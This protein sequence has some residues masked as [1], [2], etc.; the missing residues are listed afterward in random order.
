MDDAHRI[1]IPT[2]FDV[3]R[4]NCYVFA[5][6]PLT[7]VD[8]GPATDAAY[9]ELAAGLEDLGY[10]VADVEQVL[11]THPH[12]DHFGLA[13]RV[14]D[15]SG[16]AAVAHR[17]AT[18]QLRDP[19][20]HLDREQALFRPFLTAM[21]VPEQ[22]VETAVTLPDAY[23]EYQEPLAVDRELTDDD[24]V[25]AGVDLRAVHTPGH[26]PGSVCFVAERGPVAFTG[27]HVLDHISP[28]PLL[29]VAPGTDDERTRSLPAYLD[30]LDRLQAVDA[31][32]GRPGHGDDVSD[33]SARID[34]IR[35]HHHERKEHIADLIDERGTATAY[36]LM[37]EL[38]P[39]LP[40]TEVF[41][42][43]SEIIGHLDLLED[44]GRVDVTET[45]GV[46]RY[47]LD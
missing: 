27:D 35:D 45:D 41:P 36:D 7:L 44:E 22:V 2:P 1:E 4:V 20:G 26:A 11:I 17:D 13:N 5:G 28:N 23:T 16:A 43:M 18:R 47:A 40:A 14:V 37:G 30:A 24:P 15:V 21:G 12:M 38:F 25:D 39:D 31:D 8:P 9:E 6:G 29:T 10:A 19:D 46:R 33:L 34:E 3:G 42:G 32:V